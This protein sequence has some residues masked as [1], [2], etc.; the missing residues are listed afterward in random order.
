MFFEWCYRTF[1]YNEGDSLCCGQNFSGT[2]GYLYKWIYGTVLYIRSISVVY[3][4]V[5]DRLN[6]VFI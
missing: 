6:D 2:G 4:A 1:A 3:G 5:K